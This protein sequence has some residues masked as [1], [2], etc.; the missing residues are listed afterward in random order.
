MSTI[1]LLLFLLFQIHSNLFAQ[2]PWSPIHS[3]K[4]YSFKKIEEIRLEYITIGGFWNNSDFNPIVQN[5]KIKQES[6]IGIDTVLYF[7]KKIKPTGITATCDNRIGYSWNFDA[8]SFLGEKI[9]ISSNGDFLFQG[10]DTLL[11]KP[12]ASLNDFWYFNDIIT[13]TVIDIKADTI[14]NTPDSIKTILLSN[15]DTIR[16]SLNFGLLQFP[17][18]DSTGLYCTLLGL[19][20]EN[21]TWGLRTPDFWDAYEFNVGDVLMY[22]CEESA[23]QGCVG[24]NFHKIRIIQKTILSNGFTYD[25]IKLWGA[26][27]YHSCIS[28]C[29]TAFP[30]SGTVTFL[31]DNVGYYGFHPNEF[32]F[33]KDSTTSPFFSESNFLC[34]TSLNADSQIV[35]HLI[36]N[37]HSCIQTDS[38]FFTNYLGYYRYEPMLGFTDFGYSGFENAFLTNLIGYIKNGDTVGTILPD[39]SLYHMNTNRIEKN[40]HNFVAWVENP[41][42]I[43]QI[44]LK[45]REIPIETIEISLYNSNGIKIL[46]QNLFSE[47][48]EFRI[49]VPNIPSGIYVLRLRKQSGSEQYL[50]WILQY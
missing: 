40:V 39:G 27:D 6:V 46:V 44:H 1:L 20:K 35:K 29:Y 8:H 36:V 33:T 34:F 13:A 26:G 22:Q 48:S 21:N 9:I 23:F 15:S 25:Y 12:Q 18:P 32:G 17:D 30:N 10:T 19:Q 42:N 45:L 4:L 16:L 47:E 28:N 37:D 24:S 11:L 2:Q 38:T 31:N 14:W 49:D 5:I 7:E 50:K 43:P 3:D 41:A